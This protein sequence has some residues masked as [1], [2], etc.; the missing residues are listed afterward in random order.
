[1]RV[2]WNSLDNQHVFEQRPQGI[3]CIEV[4]ELGA[5]ED[6]N[7]F[8]CKCKRIWRR[9][10]GRSVMPV[11]RCI[12]QCLSPSEVGPQ[13]HHYLRGDPTRWLYF[14]GSSHSSIYR[15]THYHF[16]R[17]YHMVGTIHVNGII[18]HQESYP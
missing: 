12:L 18:D 15:Y 4:H 2:W 17:R 13:N 3:L 1:M 7:D 9:Q 8:V 14:T 10:E 5:W 11:L 6:M 16:L